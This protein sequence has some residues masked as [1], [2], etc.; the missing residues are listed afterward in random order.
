LIGENID[1]Y[2]VFM[3]DI[4]S[5][6]VFSDVSGGIKMNFKKSAAAVLAACTASGIMTFFPVHAADGAVPGDIN[7]DGSVNIADLCF[8]KSVLIE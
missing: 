8:V 5:F 7:L 4:F 1:F 2:S 3:L 6:T